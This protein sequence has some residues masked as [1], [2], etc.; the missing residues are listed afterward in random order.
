M[1]RSRKDPLPPTGIPLEG[2]VQKKGQTLIAP[3]GIDIRIQIY[4]LAQGL[5]RALKRAFVDGIT[6]L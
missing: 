2:D 6:N 3:G 5:T 4:V 1:T